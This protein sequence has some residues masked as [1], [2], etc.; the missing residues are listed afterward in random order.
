MA[1]TATEQ[2][3]RDIT[4]CICGFEQDDGFMICCNKCAVWQHV[5]CVNL[6]KSNLPNEYLCERCHPRELDIERARRIQS[7]WHSLLQT[8]GSPSGSPQQAASSTRTLTPQ[9]EQA[10]SDAT[11]A[12]NANVTST[13]TAAAAAATTTTTAPHRARAFARPLP[14]EPHAVDTAS[15]QSAMSRN[16]TAEE[17]GDGF[18]GDG[19]FKLY[20]AE[21]DE[22][23]K[24]IG[25]KLGKG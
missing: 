18:A 17:D 20:E 24:Q 4:R 1:S 16:T 12:T 23:L 3:S 21:E 5:A 25:V 13:S 7:D 15:P 11:N 6:D 19:F 9:Q 10:T 8:S 2:D 22:T 14:P